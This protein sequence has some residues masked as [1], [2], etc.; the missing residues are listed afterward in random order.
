MLRVLPKKT[1]KEQI[2]EEIGYLF[3]EETGYVYELNETACKIWILAKDGLTDEEIIKRM[4]Q[5]YAVDK[6][7]LERDVKDFLEKLM[8]YRL[9]EVIR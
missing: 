6:A 4:F 5:E 9:V 1:V 8:K 7:I 3:D 2:E